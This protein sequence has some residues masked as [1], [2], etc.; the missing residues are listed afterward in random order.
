M[1]KYTIINFPQLS[2]WPFF[3]QRAQHLRIGEW[4][5]RASIREMQCMGLEILR[6]NFTVHGMGEIDIIA[7]DGNCLIFVEVKTRAHGQ[8]G[9]PAL[10]INKE[11]RFKLWKTAHYYMKRLGNRIPRFRFD[12]VEVIYKSRLSYQIYYWPN[13]FQ[14][15]LKTDGRF[16]KYY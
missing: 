12:V 1:G 7:R 13:A 4:G 5:E 3:K 15:R 10:A 8:M 2:K 9:R 16:K 11:K 6:T 14:A